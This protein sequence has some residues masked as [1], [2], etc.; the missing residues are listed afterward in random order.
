MLEG[1]KVSHITVIILS[2]QLKKSSIP[3]LVSGAFYG[4]LWAKTFV[5]TRSRKTD[6]KHY[7]LSVIL[8]PCFL[9]VSLELKVTYVRLKSGMGT[10]SISTGHQE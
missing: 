1:N 5:N 4:Q 7:H 3:N 9:C 10:T 8:S 6:N 2:L